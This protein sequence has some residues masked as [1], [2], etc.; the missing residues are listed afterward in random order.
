MKPIK[1]LGV[2]IPEG[3][4]YGEIEELDKLVDSEKVSDR[5]AAAR[6]CYGL[7]KLI[8]DKSWIV[9][10][11]VAKTGYCPDKLIKDSSPK[12]R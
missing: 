5:V 1:C 2:Y 3:F 4:T 10:L 11:A 12:V 9:R 6:I 7:E 8:D